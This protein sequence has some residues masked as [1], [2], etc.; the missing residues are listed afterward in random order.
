MIFEKKKQKQK[1]REFLDGFSTQ[2]R[3]IFGRIFNS[4]ACIYIYIYIRYRERGKEKERG[5]EKQGDRSR[6]GQRQTTPYHC[7]PKCLLKWAETSK[8][9]K[10]I[11]RGCKRCFGACGPKAFCN[12]VLHWCKTGL[13]WC[14]LRGPAAIFSYCAMLV[15]IVSQHSLVLVFVGYRTIIAR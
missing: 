11:R 10:V 5:G 7:D 15:A 3:A 9:P 6:R 13:H 8:S 2:K 4:T 14:K 12:P 1:K